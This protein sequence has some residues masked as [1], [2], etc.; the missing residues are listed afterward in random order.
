MRQSD[1]KR[2]MAKIL[3]VK[4]GY[5]QAQI[6]DMVEVSLPTVNRWAK[7]YNWKQLKATQVIGKTETL[8]RFYEQINEI[9]AKV[10]ARPQGERYVDNKEADIISKL[11]AAIEKLEAENPPHKVIDVLRDAMN[12]TVKNRGQKN[13]MLFIKMC[14]DY[15]QNYISP[16]ID[17]EP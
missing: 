14:D 6:A 3:Y 4:N 15:V 17:K 2:E 10:Q 8:Q 12:W 7:Q 11:T 16:K 13:G 5:T 9:H 1:N